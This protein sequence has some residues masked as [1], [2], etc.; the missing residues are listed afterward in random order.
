[1]TVSTVNFYRRLD[2]QSVLVTSERLEANP[3]P[4]EIEHVGCMKTL[5]TITDIRHLIK[6]GMSHVEVYSNHRYIEPESAGASLASLDALCEEISPEVTHV[7][8]Y[9]SRGA[10][11][12]VK[13]TIEKRPNQII[14]LDLAVSGKDKVQEVLKGIRERI[15]NGESVDAIRERFVQEQGNLVQVL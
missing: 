1:M 13:A 15:R 3:F 5:L 14:L 6:Q 2:D 10:Q 7:Y 8:L 4:F 11:N 9:E 12:G